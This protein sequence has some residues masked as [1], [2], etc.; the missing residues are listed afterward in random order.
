MNQ[1]LRH[2]RADLP[3]RA[4]GTL[5]LGMAWF[6]ARALRHLAQAPPPHQAGALGLLLAA[7]AFVA[8]S[9]G[10]ALLSLGSHLFDQIEVSGRWRNA[11]PLQLEPIEGDD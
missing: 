10:C 8:A 1:G 4:G 3:I 5:L 11:H 9:I 7:I 2:E 6:A